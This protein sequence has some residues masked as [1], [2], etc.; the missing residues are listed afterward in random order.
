MIIQTEIV[1]KRKGILV[2]KLSSL[3]VVF[4]LTRETEQVEAHFSL[5]SLSTTCTTYRTN[6]K[7]YFLY[8][9]VMMGS[10]Y[11]KMDFL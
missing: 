10:K 11:M 7:V 8:N 9:S 2:R 4:S 6:N 1:R 5:N 3:L